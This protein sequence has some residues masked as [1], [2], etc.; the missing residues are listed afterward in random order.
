M[1][2]NVSVNFKITKITVPTTQKCSATVGAKV[3]LSGVV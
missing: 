1:N 3:S 2:A